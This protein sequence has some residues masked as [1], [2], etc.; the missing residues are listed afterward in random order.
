MSSDLTLAAKFK[1]NVNTFTQL[2]QA[3]CNREYA[4]E[5][6]KKQ[7]IILLIRLAKSYIDGINDDD[8]IILFL[9]NS[10]AYLYKIYHRDKN[11]FQNELVNIFG[12]IDGVGQIFSNIF[13]KLTPDIEN[14]IWKWIMALVSQS[15]EYVNQ[16]PEHKN[17]IK[18]FDK[19]YK[20]YHS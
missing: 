18:D 6:E 19:L 13:A 16:H 2:L 7:E 17:K 5:V 10:K 4:N 8:L 11:F 14:H 20:L 15:L 1:T 3:L 12:F 9:E